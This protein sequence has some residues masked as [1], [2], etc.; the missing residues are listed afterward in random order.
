[1]KDLIKHKAA[2]VAKQIE[3]N[4]STEVAIDKL[5]DDEGFNYAS[6]HSLRNDFR[7]RLYAIDT[8][9]AE[10]EKQEKIAFALELIG[11]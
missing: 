5:M 3:L 1:M 7:M 2:L 4:I 11:A 10:I 6:C 9:L 8:A